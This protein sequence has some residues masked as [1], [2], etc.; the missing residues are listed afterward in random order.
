MDENILRNV[1]M[2]IGTDFRAEQRNQNLR[3]EKFERFPLGEKGLGRLSIHKL[4][5]FIRLIT[6]VSGGEELVM[7]FDW[8][9]LESSR[10][11]NSA[12]VK[13]QRRVPITFPGNKH[14]TRLEVTKLRE[15][16]SRGELRRLHRAVNSL[17]S[18]FEG[19]SDF[20]VRF[21]APDREDWLK[22]TRD[23]HD[24]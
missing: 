5:R 17:C 19:P 15:T 12:A 21:S 22:K 10:D 9:Q 11:L 1:W 8:D 23:I 2:V 3:T 4:G 14:G 13:L 20:K 24:K 6:R 18:P 7:E 16:W